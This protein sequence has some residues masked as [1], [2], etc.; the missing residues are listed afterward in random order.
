MTRNR[1]T[2]SVPC[3]KSVVVKTAPDHLRL[4][5]MV[6]MFHV[7][8]TDLN[9]SRKFSKAILC[10]GACVCA[11]VV[12]RQRAKNAP[13]WFHSDPQFCQNQIS[14]CSMIFVFRVFQQFQV[15]PSEFLRPLDMIC[16]T[17]LTHTHGTE[18]LVGYFFLFFA[19]DGDG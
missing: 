13:K 10:R 8:K 19:M 16:Q 17:Q 9:F 7:F 11:P 1:Y 18:D 2:S 5:L 14:K 12:W 4:F 3:V 15:Q 6:R